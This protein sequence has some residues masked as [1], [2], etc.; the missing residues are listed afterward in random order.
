MKEPAFP[1]SSRD[2]R[3]AGTGNVTT[4]AVAERAIHTATVTVQAP[5]A[6]VVSTADVMGC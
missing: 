1:A 6:T 4:R 2:G 5:V 3:T